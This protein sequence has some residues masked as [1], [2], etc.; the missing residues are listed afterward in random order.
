MFVITEDWIKSNA[1]VRGG[2]TA[3]QFSA[4]GIDWPPVKGWIGRVIGTTIDETSKHVF[5][6]SQLVLEGD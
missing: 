6:T 1:S 2:W 3:K 4:I 5:E